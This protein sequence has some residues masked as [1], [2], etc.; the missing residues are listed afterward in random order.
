VM[1][2]TDVWEARNT[3]YSR[4]LK[5]RGAEGAEEKGWG[6]SYPTIGDLCYFEDTYAKDSTWHFK[7]SHLP[8]LY[9]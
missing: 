6:R 3:P 9:T 4:S 1:L 8:P 5:H 7:I 2:D